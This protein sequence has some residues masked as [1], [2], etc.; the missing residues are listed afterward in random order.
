[1]S[2]RRPPARGA[3]QPQG[4]TVPCAYE[5][6]LCSPRACI[7]CVPVAVQEIL[8]KVTYTSG[9]D[10]GIELFLPV[11]PCEADAWREGVEA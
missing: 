5:D 1:M 2:R 8:V 9:K 11:Y 10:K 6:G 7:G 4:R 3:A